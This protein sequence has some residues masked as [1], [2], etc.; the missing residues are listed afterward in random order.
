MDQPGITRREFL[1]T[2]G[3]AVAA[4]PFSSLGNP[5]TLDGLLGNSNNDIDTN[6]RKI[7][8][9]LVDR[10]LETGKY[11]P[12][13]SGIIDIY[14]PF[15]VYGHPVAINIKAKQFGVDA[16]KKFGDVI[17]LADIVEAVYLWMDEIFMEVPRGIDVSELTVFDAPFDIENG[18]HGHHIIKG[19]M[20]PGPHNEGGRTLRNHAQNLKDSA[21]AIVR[22]KLNGTVP[23]S[24]V[25]DFMK[26]KAD[27]Y[28]TLGLQYKPFLPVITSTQ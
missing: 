3:S 25:D 28:K 21:Y 7:V 4:L 1:R 22:G 11:K 10:L 5:I 14:Y 17:G 19:V 20:V 6:E 9:G 13:S 12:D 8:L 15:K 16:R 18:H 27:L 23:E 2:G 24:L 26:S